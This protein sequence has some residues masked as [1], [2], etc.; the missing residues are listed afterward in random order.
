MKK[1]LQ[2]EVWEGKR[3]QVTGKYTEVWGREFKQGEG[4]NRERTGAGTGKDPL[5]QSIYENAIRKLAT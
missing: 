3:I 5:K 1:V 2:K 4:R